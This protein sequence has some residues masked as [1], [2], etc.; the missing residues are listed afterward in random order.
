[1]DRGSD[2]LSTRPQTVEE[3]G[4]VNAT[5]AQLSAEKGELQALFQTIEQKNKLLR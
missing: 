3:I 5:H 4:A 1:M 2:A